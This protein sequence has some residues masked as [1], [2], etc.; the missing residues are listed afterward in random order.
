[1]VRLRVWMTLALL[2]M[3]VSARG[4][5]ISVNRIPPVREQRYQRLASSAIVTVNPPAT[6]LAGKYWPP[7]WWVPHLLDE[8]HKDAI[9]SYFGAHHHLFRCGVYRMRI[10]A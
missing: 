7:Q 5:D 2:A 10:N 1:M 3:C 8:D 6:Q 4:Q 9:D